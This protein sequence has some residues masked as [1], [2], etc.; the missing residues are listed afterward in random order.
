MR[1]LVI[2]STPWDVS[3][4][5]GNTFSNL[6]DGMDDV[7]IYNICCRNGENNN[8][9]VKEAIQATDKSLLKSIYKFGYDPFWKMEVSSHNAENQHLSETA[10]KKR[11]PIYFFIRDMIWKMGKCKK[12]KVLNDFLKEVN[13]DIVYLPI[14]AQHYMCDVQK[15]IIDKLN[16]PVVGHISDDVYGMK[17]NMKGFEK[18]RWKKLQKKVATL[19]KKCAYLEVFAE[20]MAKEYSEKFGVTCHL[21]GK[22]VK[23]QDIPE[24]VTFD[25]KDKLKMVYTGVLSQYRFDTLMNLGKSLKK[26]CTND[27]ITLD[28]YSQT[29]L[30]EEMKD[31]LDECP[32][33]NFKGRIDRETVDTVQSEAYMLLHIEGF[34][35]EAIH[36]SK[37]SFSTKIIDY[38]LKG[39]TIF[40]IGSQ[41]INSIMV[42]DSKN[43]GVVAKSVDEIDVK[44]KQLINGEIDIN[45][46]LQNVDGYLRTDRNIDLIRQGIKTRMEKLINERICK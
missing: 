46:I 28:V 34:N 44:I 38:M 3:N 5:F 45:Q 33:V 30:T 27:E 6:F 15:I 43:L 7:E 36:A 21:I 14:Y 20:N 31:A 18:S 11:K 41:E 17:P 25:K 16:V 35:D 19:I 40:A 2:S 42:L 24:I 37:M 29:I 13:P 1:V 8:T 39:K 32:N 4:S 23:T 9:V 10:M 12:S 22:G 26:S